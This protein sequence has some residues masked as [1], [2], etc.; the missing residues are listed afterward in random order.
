[1]ALETKFKE[2]AVMTGLGLNTDWRIDYMSQVRM[3]F[4]S[5]VDQIPT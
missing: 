4:W 2:I 1:M 5:L 3:S